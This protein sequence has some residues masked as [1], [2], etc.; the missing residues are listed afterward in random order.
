MDGKPSPAEP[1]ASC[2]GKE[3]QH[4][5][6]Q[7][8]GH[9]LAARPERLEAHEQEQEIQ[10][11]DQ[12]DEFAPRTT[13]SDEP[14]MEVLAVRTEERQASQAAP[15]QSQAGVAHRQGEHEQRGYQGRQHRSFVRI[16]N[17]V[18]PDLESQKVRAAVAQVNARGRKVIPE[19][20]DQGACH[21]A[22][23]QFEVAVLVGHGSDQ[24]HQHQADTSGQA[25]QAIYQI[26]QINQSYKPKQSQKSFHSR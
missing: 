11:I 13:Q 7:Q 4:R 16:D 24:K 1:K 22:S 12:Q 19:E 17:R 15:G 2:A 6:S 5:G 14:M 21:T 8:D 26:D 20:P 3:H 23:Q 18:Q 10:S 9:Q 25:I